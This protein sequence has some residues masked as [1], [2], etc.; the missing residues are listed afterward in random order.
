MIQL[1][2]MTGLGGRFCGSV[3]AVRRRTPPKLT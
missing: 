2:T 3:V 1:R